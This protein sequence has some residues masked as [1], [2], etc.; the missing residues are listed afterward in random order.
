MRQCDVLV[1]GGGPAGSTCAWALSRA[2]LEVLVID[3][4]RFPRDK[5]CA[6]WVTLPVFEALELDPS[7]YRAA[8]LVIEEI[9]GFR[10]STMAGREVKTLYDRAVS[11]A[12]RR[13]E[14]DHFLLRRSGARVLEN[15]ALT[16][17]RRAGDM[18]VANDAIRAPV[19]IGA[20][21]H[22]CPVARRGRSGDRSGLVVA[23]ETEFRL[24]APNECATRGPVPELFFCR[25]LDGYGWC[26][27][28]GEYL[29]VG[30]GRRGSRRFAAHVRDFVAF[31]ASSRRIPA[32]SPEPSRWC[33][34]AYLLSGARA[35]VP[36]A[37]G[38]LLVGD[39]AGLA[40]RESGEG[41]RPAV[42]SALAA[43]RTLVEAG[44]RFDRDNLWPYAERLRAWDPP[45]RGWN[46]LLPPAP[47]FIGRALL[48][49]P[50]FSRHVVIDR[51]FL[52]SG[53]PR[54]HRIDLP[55]AA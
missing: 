46:R 24:R 28:K 21:G 13:C 16:A 11:F 35:D 12:I 38:L 2:G 10:T 37:D 51:W 43:A 39:A 5:V 27:R 32:D 8:G 53:A 14:F 48:A 22:F 40:Y 3:R 42:E 23:R 6:G 15:T 25:D 33:G 7:E 45:S 31:L 55:Q 54:I 29:N 1:V 20:G 49:S 19:V 47:A 4:A 52:R 9:R 50:T 26:V 36:V 41:I 44:G 30:L 17:L 18:W 34:H